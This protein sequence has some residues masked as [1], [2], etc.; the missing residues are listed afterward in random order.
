MRSPCE[1]RSAAS[2]IGRKS[3]PQRAASQKA[4]KSKLFRL[5]SG[6]RSTAAANAC[7]SHPWRETANRR[8][9]WIWA[10]AGRRSSVTAF[11]SSRA[12]GLPSRSQR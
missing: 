12:L 7:T 9:P 5:P 6:S 3:Y 11:Q 10:A 4:Q 8:W 2:A 1:L